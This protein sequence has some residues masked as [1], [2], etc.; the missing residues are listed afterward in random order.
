[1]VS[2]KTL[3][4]EGSRQLSSIGTGISQSLQNLIRITFVAI[5]YHRTPAAGKTWTHFRRTDDEIFP[6]AC[7]PETA[8]CLTTA[9]AT[10]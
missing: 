6:A 5:S 1:M 3:A 9:T 7:L 10:T 4:I 8:T 2:P